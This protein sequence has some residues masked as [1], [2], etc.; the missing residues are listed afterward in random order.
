MRR[1]LSSLATLMYPGFKGSASVHGIVHF[2]GAFHTPT[3]YGT[4]TQCYSPL[5]L[6]QLMANWRPLHTLCTYD[7]CSTEEIKSFYL[8][9]IMIIHDRNNIRVTSIY[10]NIYSKTEGLR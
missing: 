4:S 1:S 7:S 10:F 3:H 8:V 6:I 2:G 9:K 5:D